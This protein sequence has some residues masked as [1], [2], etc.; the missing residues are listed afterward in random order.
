[1]QILNSNFILFL[2]L[3]I[4]RNTIFKY[5]LGDLIQKK[6]IPEVEI[7][8][9]SLLDNYEDIFEMIELIFS[10]NTNKNQFIY[11]DIIDKLIFIYGK[12]KCFPFTRDLS[13]FCAKA[14]F[15][16]PDVLNAYSLLLT[17]ERR[18]DILNSEIDKSLFLSLI[19]ND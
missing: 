7:L 3:A 6:R 9:K 4:P 15:S 11:S 1:M 2:N 14:Y 5:G 19:K 16:N 12:E 18:K 17:S 8:I 10:E 13:S